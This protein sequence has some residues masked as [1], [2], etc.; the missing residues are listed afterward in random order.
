MRSKYPGQALHILSVYKEK[1][2]KKENKEGNTDMTVIA[3]SLK[4]LQIMQSYVDEF[5]P[6]SVKEQS[7]D[8]IGFLA[9]NYFLIFNL[10]LINYLSNLF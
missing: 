10:V 4:N 2:Y 7:Y 5:G 1:V 3:A 9:G 8:V 6:S